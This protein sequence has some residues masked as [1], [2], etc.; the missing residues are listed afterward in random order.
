LGIQFG[1]KKL[2]A[3]LRG[4]KSGTVI[5]R[6]FVYGAEALGIAAFMDATPAMVQFYARQLQAAGEALDDLLKG[7]DHRAKVQTASSVVSGFIYTRMPETALFYVQKCFEF[8]QAGNIQ[9]VPVYGRSPEFS[10]DI[11]ET[12]VALS[13]A[14]YWA[15]YLFLVRGGPEP[16]MTAK[17]EKEFRR[18]LPV[19]DIVS[20]FSHVE[21]IFYC[22]E[23]TRSSSR[24]V[25]RRCGQKVSCSSRTQFC[26][27]EISLLT[28]S[29]MCPPPQLVSADI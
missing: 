7:N 5:H 2:D 8:A 19:S 13:Q 9:F 16:C 27:L 21:L 12:S 4:D 22:S 29:V 14:I 26:S 11:H 23:L 10:E 17:F 20:I 24:F 3:L 15:N 28:V 6:S 18:E 1:R 25:L